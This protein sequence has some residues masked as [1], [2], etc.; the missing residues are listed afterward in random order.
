MRIVFVASECVPFA[1]TGGLADVVGALP[2]A[3]AVL[4]HEVEVIIPRYRMT[5]PGAVEP[6][7]S[8]IT[9]PLRS[10]FKFASLQRGAVIKGVK[11][12]LVECPELF[13]RGGLYQSKD[14]QDYPDNPLR[15]AAF[16]LAALEGMKRLGNP[17]DVIHC[18]DWQTS[19]VPIYLKKLYAQDPFFRR[20]STMLTVHNLGYQGLF[21]AEVL[22]QISLDAGLFNIDGMEFFGRVNYLKG[23]LIFSDF[24]TTV[25]RRYAAEIQTAEFGYGLE[26]VLRSRANRLEGILNGVDYDA[27]NPATDKLIPAQYTAANTAGK[28]ACKKALLARMGVS[29]PVLSYPVIGIVSRFAAQKGF[30]LIAHLAEKLV[31]MDIYVVALGAGEPQYEQL[32]RQ[33]AADYPQKFLVKVAYDNEL[34]HQIEA[35]A[36]IFLMPSR[37]EPCGLNQIYSLKYGT[38]PVVRATG[39]LDDTIQEFDGHEGTGFKFEDYSALA[40]LDAL[41]K[42][43]GVYRQPAAWQRLM[44][45]GMA[46]DFSWTV[47]AKSYAGIYERLSAKNA[48]AQNAAKTATEAADRTKLPS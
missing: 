29:N 35:G 8:G 31:R 27:W 43:I 46:K 10:G 4:G 30:D 45:N 16:S 5:Q 23:G 44:Q 21:P 9:L 28:L 33:L 1:K 41:E 34:A 48:A 6:N 14:G 25:S 7:A 20:A 17:P 19:L 13:D 22:P 32:F 3:L 36:E 42:A 2:E 37:Y 11:H 40:L 26:G 24:I 12:Y 39:G 18:H 15:F 38:A 47:S